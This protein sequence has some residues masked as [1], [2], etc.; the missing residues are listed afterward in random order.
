MTTCK[1]CGKEVTGKKQYCG[2]S[3]K[4][5]MRVA[6]MT[7]EQME[8]YRKDARE[9][10]AA[11]YKPTEN[12]CLHCGKICS[13]KFCCRPHQKRYNYEHSP[14]YLAAHSTTPK[15]KIRAQ[16]KTAKLDR[17]TRGATH[18][19]VNQGRVTPPGD[20]PPLGKDPR[21]FRASEKVKPI[22]PGVL[23]VVLAAY[24]QADEI[25]RAAMRAR[26]LDIQF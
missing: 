23:R 22:H 24:V 26:N 2:E 4:K 21:R 8:A 20:V 16:Q 9:R 5:K 3:C 17:D 11:N 6:K 7:P 25:E 1:F 18:L 13:R 10:M 12:R 19:P 14:D 15:R